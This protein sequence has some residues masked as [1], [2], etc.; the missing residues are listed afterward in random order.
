VKRL[1]KII[2]LVSIIIFAASLTQNGYAK[3]V[4]Y[5]AGD[6]LAL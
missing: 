5:G 3:I 2:M 1:P 6:S 4:G